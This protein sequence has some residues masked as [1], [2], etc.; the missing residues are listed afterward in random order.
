MFL[1]LSSSGLK[2]VATS[3]LTWKIYM[4]QLYSEWLLGETGCKE[5]GEP[6][7]SLWLLWWLLENCSS[8]LPFSWKTHTPSNQSS[9]QSV[10]KY[11]N[12]FLVYHF[13]VTPIAP[14]HIFQSMYGTCLKILYTPI[15]NS[16]PSF[17]LSFKNASINEMYSHIETTAT[18]QL[19]QLDERRLFSKRSKNM[20][21]TFHC[22]TDI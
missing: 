6:K 21:C 10:K 8:E 20:L 14:V 19:Q 15:N 11:V 18:H 5:D 2:L 7:M 16:L 4:L 3:G 1:S 12:W 13:T 9:R 22:D 17:K